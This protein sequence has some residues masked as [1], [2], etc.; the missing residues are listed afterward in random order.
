MNTGP[1]IVLIGS[2]IGYRAA[3]TD[4]AY[5]KYSLRV[6]FYSVFL[7]RVVLPSLQGRSILP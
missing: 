3:A 1:A 7:W 5:Y 4:I 6:V 2:S